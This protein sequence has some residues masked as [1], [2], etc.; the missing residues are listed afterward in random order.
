MPLSEVTAVG[1]G[2]VAVGPSLRATT[3]VTG[4]YTVQ[5]NDQALEVS[6]SVPITITLP[7]AALNNGRYLTIKR[8]DTGL[9]NLQF[10]DAGG[11]TIENLLTFKTA[12]GK[13]THGFRASAAA[14]DWRFEQTYIPGILHTKYASI[15][16]KAGD[17]VNNPTTE[18]QFAS[19][20][21]FAANYLGVGQTFR[22]DF[23]GLYTIPTGTLSPTAQPR[24]KV[25]SVTLATTAPLTVGV[26][27][28]VQ[29]GYTG[30]VEG[31]IE[32][33]GVNGVI[34]CGGMVAFQTA[35]G[36]APMVAQVIIT[37]GRVTVDTTVDSV[38]GATVITTP[39]A[40]GTQFIMTRFSLS[41]S[42]RGADSN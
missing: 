10:V 24:I 22:L 15:T 31:V 39:S 29:Y 38:F 23:A 13:T 27:T 6:S 8:I 2:A 25:G 26:G 7:S 16:N 14:N 41:T 4:N 21:I 18:S 20:A 17:T 40:A 11:G 32:A 42:K 3:L 1:L 9:L 33:T 34:N 37:T 28:G 35:L 19:Q 36:A 12:A 30:Y 5:P